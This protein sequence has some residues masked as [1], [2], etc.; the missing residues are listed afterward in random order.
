[1]G[2][3]VDAVVGARRLAGW[4]L[5]ME[6]AGLAQLIA[7]WE[8][9][10]PVLDAPPGP[11]GQLE[12][13][14][15]A[16]ADPDLADRLYRLIRD[17]QLPRPV[18]THQLAEPF[19]IS[20][21]SA[22][23]GASRRAV[24]QRVDA[25]RALF[26][27]HRLPRS[28]DLLRAGLLDWTKLST[29]LYGTQDL[30][31][32][33]CRLVEARVIPDTDLAAAAADPLD[34]RADPARPGA[35]LPTVT[36]ITNPQLERKIREAIVVIDA[37]TAA[38]R[39]AQARARRQVR[40]TA[41]NDTMARLEIEAAQEAVA[42]VMND[43]DQEVKKA[44]AAG[45]TRTADQIRTDH[46]IHRL[47][48]G[49]YGRTHSHTTPH[50]ARQAHD[51]TGADCTDQASRDAA[52]RRGTSFT[53]D[54]DGDGAH[55]CSAHARWGA[56]PCAEAGSTPRTGLAVS[57]T[58]TLSTWLGWPR[59]RPCSIGSG[60][61][62]PPS[63]AGSPPTPPGTTPP[64]PPGAASWSTTTTTPACS[65][66]P[67]RSAPPD[68]T[69]HHASRDWSTTMHPAC[70]F[71]GCPVPA[72]RCDI[73]HRVPYDQ[74]DPD[75][76]PTCSCNLHP[77][78]RTHHRLKTAGLL[79]PTPAP[80]GGTAGQRGLDH[81][82]RAHL[83]PPP[84]APHPTSRRPGSRSPSPAPSTSGDATG[85]TPTPSPTPTTP[86]TTSGAPAPSKHPADA[87][88]P[89]RHGHGTRHHPGTATGAPPHA[90][91]TGRP[92]VLS[93]TAAGLSG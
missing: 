30:S 26:L 50:S 46:A 3:V 29:L 67:T 13:D 93:P 19:V 24:G 2:A 16:D 36:R 60:R 90:P 54:S 78:C 42:A 53:G 92:T 39:A 86:T 70:T 28:R 79:T 21:I 81:R 73:D 10:P 27:D 71:P 89:P 51:A 17:W 49:A 32:A 72:H 55:G 85:T 65:R 38:E 74:A 14:P 45:D 8:G 58:M 37:E 76:G 22:A 25:A 52:G 56:Q 40:A 15:C 6:L 75:A 7:F 82:H 47:T 77:L 66:S 68:T 31:D 88:A 5:W 18:N 4:A 48:G 87:S 83:P 59:T 84:A 1:M 63:P 44:K 12:P 41:L 69:R 9:A 64:P 23:A 11:G 61:S 33:V 80:T 34:V 20:E 43:L 57:L 62:L 35:P 91:R